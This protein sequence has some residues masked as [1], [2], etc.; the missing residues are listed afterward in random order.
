MVLSSWSKTARPQ[1]YFSE[2]FFVELSRATASR[3]LR[4]DSVHCLTD[5]GWHTFGWSDWSDSFASDWICFTFCMEQVSKE[6]QQQALS[7]KLYIFLLF[8]QT[9][10]EYLCRQIERR[11]AWS[12]A[13]RESGLNLL[14]TWCSQQLYQNEF[15]SFDQSGPLWQTRLLWQSP[16]HNVNLSFWWGTQ[17]T[18]NQVKQPTELREEF[19]E[20]WGCVF[21]LEL[22][23][24]SCILKL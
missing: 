18:V 21:F 7:Q 10:L 15:A 24:T 19:W 12:S 6:V 11:V 20:I 13:V 17:F 1:A 9:S 3:R 14:N 2:D 5:K 23:C 22:Y 4:D 8:S 16:R